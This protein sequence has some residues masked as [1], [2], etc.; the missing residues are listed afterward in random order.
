MPVILYVCGRWSFTLWG[1]DGLRVLENRAL[2]RIFGPKAE[3][4]TGWLKKYMRRSFMSFNITRVLTLRRKSWVG[5]AERMGR[6]EL[7]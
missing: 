1:E 7:A 3:T 5:H 2:F 4:G 6:G